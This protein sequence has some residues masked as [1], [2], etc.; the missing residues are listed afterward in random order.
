M[1]TAE[2]S[3][4]K[5]CQQFLS[6]LDGAGPSARRRNRMVRCRECQFGIVHRKI[7]ALEVEQAAR[8]AEIMQQMTIDMEQIGIIANSRNDVLVPY[9]G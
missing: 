9:F 7:A 8:P 5:G 2:V 6:D 1:P 3:T 4:L